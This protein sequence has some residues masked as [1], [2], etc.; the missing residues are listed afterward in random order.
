MRRVPGAAGHVAVMADFA[1]VL[2][3]RVQTLDRYL[4]TE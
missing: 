4:L 1:S 3:F 2:S